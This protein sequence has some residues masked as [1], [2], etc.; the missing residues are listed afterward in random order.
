VLATDPAQI[1]GFWHGVNRDGFYFMINED[2]TCWQGM[3]RDKPVVNCTYAFDGID[4]TFVFVLTPDS[5]LPPCPI[6]EAIYQA[7]LIDKD[8]IRFIKVQDSCAPRVSSTAQEHYKN[9]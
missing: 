7:Q 9:P 3:L 6:D 8:R 4:I 2:G 5:S 1:A